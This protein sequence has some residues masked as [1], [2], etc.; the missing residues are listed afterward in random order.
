MKRFSFLRLMLMKIRDA[1][2]TAKRVIKKVLSRLSI[3]NIS[4]LYRIYISFAIIVLGFALSFGLT[5]LYQIDIN[6]SFT[7]VEQEASPIG[8]SSHKLQT[9]LL[10][11]NQALFRIIGAQTPAEVDNLANGLR[12]ARVQLDADLESLEEL[13][14]SSSVIRKSSPE[15]LE[16]VKSLNKFV[17]EYLEVTEQ[18]P[19]NRR[20]FLEHRAKINK[21]Q[22]AT[23]G[24]INLMTLEID[25]V[26]EATGDDFVRSIVVYMNPIRI[27]IENQL[28]DAFKLS[29][30]KKIKEIY[31][32]MPIQFGMFM[33]KVE[34]MDG[35]VP[36]TIDNLKN[37]YLDPFKRDIME[38]KGV[39]YQTYELAVEGEELDVIIERGIDLIQKTEENLI[40]LQNNSRE[41]SS[42]ASQKV[43]TN[44]NL[45]MFTFLVGFIVIMLVVF[46]VCINLAVSIKKPMYHL[47]GVMES[48]ANGDLTATYTF[49][50]ENEFGRIGQG[51][52]SL[53]EKNRNLLK[54]LSEMVKKLNDTSSR[55]TTIVT[56]AKD[57]IDVQRRE[58][59]M[60][61]T[62]THEL[63]NT[64]RMVEDS[65]KQTLNEVINAG[66]VSDEGRKIM[67]QNIT[68][69]HKLD[70][71]L[72][73]TTESITRVNEMGKRIS[74]VISI[75]RG[76]A[77]QTNL[78][79]LNA[80]IEA[81]RAGEQGR[82]FAVV[83][84]E[85]R[86]LANKT[87]DSTK[88]ITGVIEELQKT[89]LQAVNTIATCDEEMNASL[90][91]SSRANSAI[92][93]IMGCIT[94]IDEMSSQ[95]VE[96]THEQSQ[97][98]KEISKNI[99]RIS[100]LSDENAENMEVIKKS[101]DDLDGIAGVQ[102]GIIRRYK[103]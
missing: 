64:I 98:I 85:V 73:D 23:Q 25:R 46:L 27:G 59:T 93:E 99:V 76:I 89:I 28:Y 81:A 19:A 2:Q 7:A 29:S 102:S 83:A 51:L 52:N 63:E 86:T 11:A 94:T 53:I 26:A 87:S 45:A 92:E 75:I 96:S 17:H 79:A 95:I 101:C 65:S 13:V 43:H 72:K 16:R 88:Q 32:R 67:S 3:K 8:I 34:E 69:T 37:G 22:T 35:E 6:S 60:V 70:R 80:A 62:A 24:L 12:G 54:T 78:L 91:Q 58:A 77:E 40:V 14:D 30:S 47:I 21:A 36:G 9:S 61:A 4:L 33:E 31:D 48:S 20:S 5:S 50:G 82:G 71:K 38:P 1:G 56:D 18:I 90:E 74:S 49:E 39:L 103:I 42:K 10:A 57:A 68:T 97:A 100:S 15:I 44:I 41:F 66:K 84:D 55:N